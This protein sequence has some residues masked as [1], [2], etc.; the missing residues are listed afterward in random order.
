M[1]QTIHRMMMT[2]PNSAMTVA[3]ESFDAASLG[4]NQALVEVAGCGVCHTD[5]GFFYDGVRTRKPLPLCLGHEISGRVAAAGCP[6]ALG[7]PGGHETSHGS[8]TLP[9]RELL[10]SGHCWE[11][12]R[13]ESG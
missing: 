5:L 2:E 11:S 6:A 10:I 1:S 13:A 9:R 7:A 4:D 8:D 3:T 12:T